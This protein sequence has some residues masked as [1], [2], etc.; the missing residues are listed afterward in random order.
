M[1]CVGVIVELNPFHNGHKLHIDE[2]R[3][4]T[5]CKYIVAIMSGNF[6]Q[7]GEPALCDKWQRT[8]M[9]LLNGVDIVIELPLQ[10]V[11]SGADY[12]AR[13]SVG[14][15][16]AT[17]VVDTLSF[18]SEHGD[19]KAILDAANIL[20][21]E[22]PLYKENLRRALNSGV[23]FAA[24]RGDALAACLATVPDGVLTKP[25][26]CLA[27]EYCKSLMLLNSNITPITT[28]RTPSGTSAT[29]IRKA[30]LHSGT[31]SVCSTMPQN[32]FDILCSNEHFA[33]LDDY[34]NI[35]RHL[36]YTR[37]DLLSNMSEGLGNRIKAMC[38]QHL[39]LSAL[40]AAVKTKRYT[41]TRLQREILKLLLSAD[42][43]DMYENAGGPQYIRV[44]G[45]RRHASAFVGE[46]TKKA[47]LPVITHGAEMDRLISNGGE[48]A[49]MLLQEFVAGDVYSLATKTSVYKSER[50]TAMV[51]L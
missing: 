39:K 31:G 34:S 18:G 7:R 22:P 37:P 2:T 1:Y 33:Q 16:E 46:I 41:F 27:I 24:A 44:L 10:Y 21:C 40:L 42:K 28:H 13:G 8:R 25:N 26:N 48:P 29:A 45:F 5:G 20:A 9:A 6:V 17:G 14:L 38:G 32:T 3:K 19:I 51:I 15:L 47:S 12:F 4:T 49:A 36:I 43:I 35:V 11:I 30:I 23:S 50:G